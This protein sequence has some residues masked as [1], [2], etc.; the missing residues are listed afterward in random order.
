MSVSVRA[1]VVIGLLTIARPCF[2]WGDKGHQLVARIAARSVSSTVKRHIVAF[3]R[4]ASPDDL[5]LQALIGKTGDP[6][7][8]LANFE[9]ALAKMAIW[10]DHMPGGKGITAPWHFVDIA[11]FEGPSH[12]AERCGA[13]GCVSEKIPILAA[14]IKANKKLV[15]TLASGQTLTFTPPQEARFLLH[16]LGDIHQ[17]LHSATNADAGGNC[18]DVSGF[19][20]SSQLH[21][22]W[23]AALVNAAIQGLT[24]PAKS[25][26]IEF[27]GE[28]ASVMTQTNADELA[29]ES[30]GVAKAEVYAKA[31]PVAVPVI[32]HFVDLTPS[33]CAT[34]AP[35]VIRA[36]HVDGPGSFNNAATL[37]LVRE[38]IFM[39]GVRLAAILENIFQ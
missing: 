21:S 23:D 19:S 6:Q 8:S 1:C 11:L 27:Q 13:G 17:P 5:S 29:G 10:P 38:R 18:V 12:L 9:A 4:K 33:E 30:F 7:P 22:V 31:R 39:A 3:L 28:M 34:K 2:A 36:L 26:I 24:N 25:L 15:V 20:G 32:D 14:N 35:A 37:A 16:F